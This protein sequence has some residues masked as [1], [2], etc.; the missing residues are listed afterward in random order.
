MHVSRTSIKRNIKNKF[1]HLRQVRYE[2]RPHT[3]VYKQKRLGKKNLLKDLKTGKVERNIV[4]YQ[5]LFTTK[6]YRNNLINRVFI[7]H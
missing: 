3:P 5:K 1:Q 4:T 2:S 7:T 6:T